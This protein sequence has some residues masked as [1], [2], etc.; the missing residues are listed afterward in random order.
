MPFHTENIDAMMSQL[1]ASGSHDISDIDT[2]I[3]DDFL[4][5]DSLTNQCI[6]SFDHLY[7]R[8]R[9]YSDVNRINLFMDTCDYRRKCIDGLLS[10]AN[11][12]LL[13]I[14]DCLSPFS[15]NFFFVCI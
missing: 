6:Y 12:M 15:L 13:S 14:L 10:C 11:D 3:D 8:P 9:F 2:V 1:N 4:E 5:R 7:R